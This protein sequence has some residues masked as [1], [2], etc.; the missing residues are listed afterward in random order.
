MK[1]T[2]LTIVRL[3]DT[4]KPKA[5]RTPHWHRLQPSLFLGYLPQRG[6]GAGT[7]SAKARIDGK[8]QQKALGAFAEVPEAERFR[9]AKAAAEAYLKLEEAGG[10][11]V[12]LLDTV[13]DACREYAKTHPS[14]TAFF[15]LSVYPNP[16]AIVKLEKLRRAHLVAWREDL[17]TRA[18]KGRKGAVRQRANSSINREMAP[19]RAALNKVLAK[20]QPNTEAAWQE[21]IKPISNEDAV[22]RRNLYLDHDQRRALLANI[23]D[24]NA[25]PFV[26][27]LCLL[28]VR[29]GALS[30]LTV[31]SYVK[32]TDELQIGKDKKHKP[33]LIHLNDPATALVKAQIAKAKAGP[34]TPIDTSAALLFTRANGQAW[35]RDY[36]NDP[37]AQAAKAAKLPPSTTYTLRHSTITDLVMAGEPILTIAQLAGT[38]VKMIQDHY[39]HLRPKAS[40]KALDALAL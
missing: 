19:L 29:P 39:G 4:L 16:I 27:A 3:R 20:G 26:R 6:G 18:V 11:A 13:E 9:K 37:I 32:Q 28:P 30:E 35:D 1:M 10:R 31:A 36:W 25:E 21:A 33:R 17:E 24:A 23:S 7:W 34:V 5:N 12:V 8:A 38:S 40:R 2:D 14:A 22:N 15:R